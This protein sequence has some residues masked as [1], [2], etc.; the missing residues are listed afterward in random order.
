MGLREAKFAACSDVP[1][2]NEKEGEGYNQQRHDENYGPINTDEEAH[3]I[4]PPGGPRQSLGVQ[5][6]TDRF[7]GAR[8]EGPRHLLVLAKPSKHGVDGVLHS[9]VVHLVICELLNP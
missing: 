2:E 6:D 7:L 4:A 3:T 9:A 5:E 1:E 8:G